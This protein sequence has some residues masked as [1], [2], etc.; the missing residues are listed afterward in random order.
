MK[1]LKH[2]NVMALQGQDVKDQEVC[3]ALGISHEHANKPSINDEA[4]KVTH[5]QNYAAY[6]QRGMADADALALANQHADEA[7]LKV[8]N[9][10]T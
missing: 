3:D 5:K 6:K 1:Q 2:Y 9:L 7:R 8:K 10:L 4:I